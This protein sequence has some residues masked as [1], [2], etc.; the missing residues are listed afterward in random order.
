MAEGKRLETRRLVNRAARERSLI[1][2][3]GKLFAARGYEATTTREIAAW[4]GCAEGLI[5]R[6]FK[7]KAGLLQALVELHFAEGLEEFNH[8]APPATTVSEEIL[9]LVAWDVEHI[10][11]DRDFLRVSIPQLLLN[12]DLGRQVRSLGPARHEARVEGRLSKHKEFQA[13]PP[14]ERQ[15]LVYLINMTG[16]TFGFMRPAMGEDPRGERAKAAVVAKMLSELL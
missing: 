12:A 2:A 6:Y 3:A 9:Q 7:G 8:T 16:F 10:W 4:A 1:M 14:E 13:L 15:A 5:S 11:E